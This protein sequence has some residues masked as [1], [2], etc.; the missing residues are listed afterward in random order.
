MKL[1]RRQQTFLASAV[2]L[3]FAAT[4]SQSCSADPQANDDGIFWVDA[5]EAAGG[6]GGSVGAA[7]MNGGAS[8]GAM[9]LGGVMPI[10]GGT[11]LGGSMGIGGMLGMG[12][13]GS[14][15][16]IGVGGVGIGGAIGSGGLGLGGA[17]AGG[18]GGLPVGVGGVVG[19]GGDLG[20]GGSVPDA[21]LTPPNPDETVVSVV[22]STAAFATDL[23]QAD[24]TALVRE[25]VALAGGLDDIIQP[26]DV[27]VLK[28]NLVTTTDYVL[29][30]YEGYPLDPEVNGVTTDWRVAAAVVELVMEQ[31]PSVIYVMEG[32]AMDTN[33]AMS[34][35]GYTST[36]FPTATLLAIEDDS[37]GWQETDS[38]ALISV[39]VPNGLLGNQ[40]Y[41]NRRLYEAAVLVSLPTLKTHWHAVVTGA[42]KNLGIGATPA[43]MYGGSES[44]TSR[45]F[46]EVSGSG[47]DHESVAL[48]QWI[49][50]YYM[51]R[52]ANFSVMDGLQGIQNGPTPCYDISGA[53]DIA[54]DQKNMRLILAARDGVALDTIEALIVQWDP[55]SVE[56][57]N[58][59]NASGVGTTNT[60]N[61]RVVGQRVDQV[62][63][64]FEGVTTEFAFGGAM[65][66]D[67]TPPPLTLNSHSSMAGLLMLDVAPDADLR[68][69]EVS[70]GGV[71]IEPPI[72]SDFGQIT[73]DISA[74]GSGTYDL[75]VRGYDYYLNVTEQTVL[76][77]VVVQ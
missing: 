74:L 57:L 59:L 10:G 24:I 64:P 29:P 52:P 22:R 66:T 16:M 65:V 32:S 51:A 67:F 43:N 40:Y 77:A 71:P 4:Q 38:P 56:Y 76:S 14:G 2:A 61:I 31:A 1:S 53:T 42:V 28:P 39:N 23:A 3:M 17:A 44:G 34:A 68:K 73:L 69:V 19:V 49:H 5:G 63:T 47:I 30:D 58:L 60:A 6:S 8:G 33:A 18:T 12:G 55:T 70:V 9:G 11:G 45:F 75:T 26:N 62:R 36:N 54:D 7:G 37:G 13:M 50:D 15:G 41:F 72:S 46:S 35:L 21:S 20:S 27:V 25:A 48:H